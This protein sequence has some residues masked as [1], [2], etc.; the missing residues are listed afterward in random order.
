M[1]LW[2]GLLVTRSVKGKVWTIIPEEGT[3]VAAALAKFRALELGG[4]LVTWTWAWPWRPHLRGSPPRRGPGRSPRPVHGEVGEG[5]PSAGHVTSSLALEA[6]GP[7]G[8]SKADTPPGRDPLGR[9]RRSPAPQPGERPS[10]G[11]LIMRGGHLPHATQLTASESA[12][13]MPRGTPP[14][15]C[16]PLPKARRSVPGSAEGPGG[17]PSG[18]PRCPQRAAAVCADG[19]LGRLG[20]ISEGSERVSTRA[21]GTTRGRL[22]RAR[23]VSAERRGGSPQVDVS[24]RLRGQ[25]TGHCHVARTAGS[26]QT[27][28]ERSKGAPTGG[29]SESVFLPAD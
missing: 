9:L 4:C 1:G 27:G 10:R 5:L 14:K 29:R 7:G 15:W 25:R 3:S 23:P 22:P 18:G 20:S 17:V 24:L 13:R 6:P 2:Q 12:W 21:C 28:E 11:A 19:R 16:T 8:A 26:L